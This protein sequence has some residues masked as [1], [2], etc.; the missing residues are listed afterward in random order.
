MACLPLSSGCP[1]GLAQRAHHTT[2]RR[3]PP[4]PTA[5]HRATACGHGQKAQGLFP[6]WHSLAL[7]GRPGKAK[8][9]GGLGSGGA[10]A[11]GHW[12]SA[13]HG[14]KR[15]PTQ[16]FSMGWVPCRVIA[17]P[18]VGWAQRVTARGETWGA[19]GG[20]RFHELRLTPHQRCDNRLPLSSCHASLTR[21][22][23]CVPGA[24]SVQGKV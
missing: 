4:S 7:Q 9:C 18:G 15:G 12:G 6:A 24:H 19:P 1:P 11:L 21:M 3:A 16:R 8:I 2:Q 10:S 14:M 23:W 22:A 5:L 17:S 13:S 20:R